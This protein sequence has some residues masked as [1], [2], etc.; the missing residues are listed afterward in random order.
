MPEP[1]A[2]ATTLVAFSDPRFPDGTLIDHA[3]AAED[4]RPEE[5]GSPFS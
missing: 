3:E 2:G 1:D 4:P 5:S